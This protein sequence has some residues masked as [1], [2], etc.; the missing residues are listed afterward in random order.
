MKF[1]PI[2]RKKISIFNFGLWKLG[3]IYKLICPDYLELSD[4]DQKQKPFWSP[5]LAVPPH[6]GDPASPLITFCLYSADSGHI[7]IGM[8]KMFAKHP[9]SRKTAGRFTL[10]FYWKQ[11]GI[12]LGIHL[13]KKGRRKGREKGNLLVRAWSRQA[14]WKPLMMNCSLLT[15]SGAE[16]GLQTGNRVYS[17]SRPSRCHPHLGPTWAPAYL[18]GGP[19]SWCKEQAGRGGEEVPSLLLSK[20]I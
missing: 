18:P 15:P 19:S 14:S 7:L 1:I 13:H 10:S 11:S 2:N 8:L 3:F 6:P 20:L 4:R 17:S 5:C 9:A 12:F 16:Y